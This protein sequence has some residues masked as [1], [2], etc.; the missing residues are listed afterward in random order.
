MYCEII[1]IGNE[2]ISG[3]THDV[4]SWYAAG[5]L[6][7][8]GLEVRRITSVGDDKE[9]VSMALKQALKKSRFIIITGGL[10]T[11]DDDITSEIVSKALNR[12][13]FLNKERL[14]QIRSRAEQMGI[15]VTPAVEKMAWMPEGSIL[16]S[17]D[18]LACGFFMIEGKTHLYFLPGVPDQMRQLMDN[19]VLPHILGLEKT[20]PVMRHRTLKLYGINEPEIAERLKG[21]RGKTGDIVL[22]FYPRFPENQITLSLRNNDGDTA[23]RELNR[24]EVEIRRLVGHYIFADENEDM[25]DIVGRA[26]R[27]RG[28]TIAGAESCTGGMIGHRLT[29]VAGSSEYFQGS[30]VAY[31]NE[32]KTA[33][34][35]VRKETIDIYGAV[36]DK[37]VRE[38]AGGIRERMNADLGLAVTGIAGPGGGSKEK[39]VGTVYVGLATGDK[40]FS[41][42]YHFSGDR[43][44]IKLNT[45]NAALDWVRRYLNGYPFLPGI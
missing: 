40:V 11:T 21:L 30:I 34:L 8:A 41:G 27:E 26:L 20:L 38:M 5:K 10:G 16:L 7:F 33:F 17:Q 24:V 25:E 45:S 36:S 14:K 29:N 31:S 23:E 39:P 9:M 42:R 18:S 15:E 2:L 44:Q 19:F 12:P 32:S 13:L 6:T 35:N 28:L 22:G 3:R 43:E 4:N 1:A 37:T